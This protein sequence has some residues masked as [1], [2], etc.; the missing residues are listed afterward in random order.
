MVGPDSHNQEERRFVGELAKGFD[1]TIYLRGVGIKGLRW[2][3]IASLQRRVA[4]RRIHKESSPLVLGSLAIVP[5]RRLA[6]NLN[7]SWLRTQLK[8]RMHDRPVNWTLWIRFPSPELMEAVRDLPVNTLVYE[9]IDRYSAADDLSATEAAQLE[10]AEQRL[11]PRTLVIAGGRQLAERFR[12]AALDASWL[13]F[14][15]DTQQ[16]AECED[17]LADLSHPRIGFVGS[18]D[19]RVDEDL[20]LSIA[21]G[22][23][24]WQI[25]LAGPRLGGW[26]R[27]LRHLRNVHWLG[28]IE[29]SRVR[30]VV[31]GFDAAIIPYRLTDWTRHC[32]PVKV[33]EYLAEGKPVVATDLSELDILKDVVNRVSAESFADALKRALGAD[34]ATLQAKRR[35]ASRRYTLQDRAQRAIELIRRPS[36]V[37]IEHASA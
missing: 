31:R 29:A 4:E 24:D 12:R 1:Q 33:F 11:D 8:K 18:L 35:E 20:V 19:W 28:V 13:P 2:H 9:P 23:K 30:A 15:L 25:L 17:V 27:R 22:H 21:E 14:G 36:L 3:Q 37:G 7:V 6:L 32:L 34:N 10:L 26:G 5:F 16:A